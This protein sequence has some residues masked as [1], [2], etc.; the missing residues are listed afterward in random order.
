MSFKKK[1]MPTFA[2]KNGA[3]AAPLQKT[4]QSRARGELVL[5]YMFV[6]MKKNYLGK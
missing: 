1:E 3:L 4:D 6:R 5:S 2:F